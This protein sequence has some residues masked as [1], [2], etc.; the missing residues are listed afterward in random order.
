M[1]TQLLLQMLS[2]CDFAQD[3]KAPKPAPAKS[4][5]MGRVTGFIVGFGSGMIG[6]Y[7]LLVRE[8]TSSTAK[9][10]E[11]NAKLGERLQALESKLK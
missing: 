2:K 3:R 6:A 8:I 11:A 7:F 9:L 1:H 4:T 5:L 10:S